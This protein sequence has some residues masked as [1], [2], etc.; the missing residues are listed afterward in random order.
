MVR[1]AAR[2]VACAALLT[3]GRILRRPAPPRS[4][5][6]AIAILGLVNVTIAFAGTVGIG[7]WVA[8]VLA[9]AQTAAHR[10]PAWA[11]Y[12]AC[13]QARNLAGLAVGFAGLIVTASPRGAGGSALLSLGAAAASTVGSLLARRLNGVGVVMLSG[14]QFLFGG[15]VLKGWARAVEGVP[16]CTGHRVPSPH[17][18]SWP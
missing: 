7:L 2:P 8:A 17:S 4:A 1:R 6:P 12:L 15:G 18:R 14:W 10:L 11:L 5:W 3:V 9:N 13:A 16:G